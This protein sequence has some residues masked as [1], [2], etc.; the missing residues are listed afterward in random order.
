MQLTFEILVNPSVGAAEEPR[1]SKQN[2]AIFRLFSGGRSVSNVQL[3]QVAR[4][5]NARLWELR[6]ALVRTGFCID[7]ISKTRR[8][9]CFY[10]L[11]P[12]EQSSFY[13]D[14]RDTL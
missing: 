3:A 12:V 10:K 13:R 11:V 8:G 4:Q 2:R 7:L 9:L 1:L 5:Y 6:R 14:H